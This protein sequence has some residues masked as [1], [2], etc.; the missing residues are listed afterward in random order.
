MKLGELFIQLTTQGDTKKLEKALKH[1]KEAEK[2]T[3]TQLKLKRDLAKATT[4]EEKEI[5]RKNYAQQKEID[6]TQRLLNKQKERN[7]AIMSGIKGFAGFITAVSLAV[8]VL[9]R[10]V[11]AS[12]KANQ[13]VLTVSQISGMSSDLINKYASASMD[14]NI[15]VTR[16]SVAQ[17]IGNLSQKLRGLQVGEVDENMLQGMQLLQVMGGKSFN[18][19]GLNA[20]QFLENLRSGLVGINDEWASDILQRM[21]ISPDLLPMLRMSKEEFE[22]TKSRFM[23][24][25]EM[26]EQQKL[27]QELSRLKDEI[28]MAFQII[29]TK[30]IPPLNR[31]V[32]ILNRLVQKIP[33]FLKG[34]DLPKE[35]PKDVKDTITKSRGQATAGVGIALATGRI[36]EAITVALAEIIGEGLFKEYKSSGFLQLSPY[37]VPAY[38]TGNTT[39]NFNTTINTTQSADKVM[40]DN[41]QNQVENAQINQQKG[42]R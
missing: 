7:Q 30:L 38:N 15:N 34:E 6:C 17:T 28:K 33:K 23:D 25:A 36:Y 22:K 20:E 4:D 2:E 31:L 21:G 11:N 26:T 24:E 16:E 12:A 9:D 41:F 40:M 29:S 39:N 35:T 18:P 37:G 8:A 27:V 42:G 1:L 14:K 13:S 3:R 19:Y 5:I 10:F 32:D